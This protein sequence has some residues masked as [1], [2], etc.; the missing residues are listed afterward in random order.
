MQHKFDIKSEKTPPYLDAGDEDLLLDT[1]LDKLRS[2]SVDGQPLGGVNRAPLVDG[3]ADNVDD[4]A[5]KG[6]DEYL[7]REYRLFLTYCELRLTCR[8]SLRPRG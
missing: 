2:L 5:N 4:S 8:G 6:V 1:H 7:K 3:V